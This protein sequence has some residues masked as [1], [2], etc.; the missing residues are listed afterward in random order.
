MT[1]PFRIPSLK[2]CVRIVLLAAVATLLGVFD[3][4]WFREP[5]VEHLA[6]RSQR[7]V[8]IDDI[9]VGI[10]ASLEPTVR[11][12]GVRIENAPWADTRRPLAVASEAAFTFSWRSLVEWRPVVSRLKLVDAEID[13]ERRADGLRNWR[14]RQPDD[15]GPGQVTVLSLQPERTRIRFLHQSLG[16][17]L[18]ATA[19]D[20][21]NPA[22]LA[23]HPL[24]MPLRIDIR[25]DLGDTPFAFETE[26]AG[27]LTFLDTGEAFPLRGH[28]DTGRARLAFEGTVADLFDP[29]TVEATLRLGGPDLGPLGKALS[30]PLPDT[31]PFEVQA[32]LHKEKVLPDYVFTHVRAAIGP[33]ELTGNVDYDPGG[34]RPIL[35]A[36]LAGDRVRLADLSVT[37][38]A[39]EA[40][41]GGTPAET[42]SSWPRTPISPESW[43]RLD[44]HLELKLKTVQTDGRVPLLLQSLRVSAHLEDGALEIAPFHFNLAGGQSTLRLALDTRQ[45]PPAAEAEF[46][47]RQLRL[48]KLLP[49]LDD[50][51]RIT[52]PVSGQLRLKARGRSLSA[53]AGS[54]G[55][56][57]EFTLEGGSLARTLESKLALDGG[58]LLRGLFSSER[59]VALRCGVL[60]FDFKRGQGTARQVWLETEQTQTR[61]SGHIDL[62]EQRFELLLAPHSKDESLFALNKPLRV[63]G[64]SFAEVPEVGL[65]DRGAPAAGP[66]GCKLSK[67]PVETD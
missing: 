24:P 43:R 56:S 8:E 54:A 10:D 16:L 32:E 62:G 9:Q 6:E 65:S 27:R 49:D 53:M 64:S 12:R 67:T 58:K 3:W 57:A 19:S 25:G 11:L 18:T 15:R 14:L 46:T 17:D 28:V 59:Q 33:S 40:R 39:L 29:S 41:G 63:H 45:E 60:A 30:I 47:L 22:T 23:R 66:A 31:P 38:K 21:P 26:A 7:R 61:G 34:E 51:A 2:T 4:N 52:G 44:A 50:N 35:R 48:E 5:L 20:L 13:L 37:D 36:T 1:L 42:P 55:G